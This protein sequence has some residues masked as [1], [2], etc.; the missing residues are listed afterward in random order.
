M[1]ATAFHGTAPASYAAIPPY[2]AHCRALLLALKSLGHL[3]DLSNTEPPLRCLVA[4]CDCTVLISVNPC[5]PRCDLCC[6]SGSS[7]TKAA[8]LHLTSISLQKADSSFGISLR[9]PPLPPR[10]Y[11]LSP[12]GR[13]S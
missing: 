11:H 3:T 9:L 5:R 6:V 7:A 2:C 8:C 4:A 10:A 13:V 1:S 12:V